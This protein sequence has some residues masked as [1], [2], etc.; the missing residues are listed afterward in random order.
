[1]KTQE[2]KKNLFR[3]KHLVVVGGKSPKNSTRLKQK[4]NAITLMRGVASCPIYGRS[5]E[6]I[7]RSGIGD[8]GR[9]GKDTERSG[10]DTG[11]FMEISEKELLHKRDL[12]FRNFSS[13]YLLAKVC[14][15]RNC[16]Y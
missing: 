6:D 7:R 4:K 2:K 1:V 5:G 10:G 16:Q 11:K 15:S 9:S 3:S 13:D 12:V 8:T 14:N